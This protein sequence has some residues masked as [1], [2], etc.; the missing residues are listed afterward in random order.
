VYLIS[1]NPHQFKQWFIDKDFFG[2]A[3]IKKV[4]PVLIPELNYKEMDVLDGLKARRLWMKTVLEDKN[5][6][7][8]E[9]IIKNLIDYCTLDTFAMVRILEELKKI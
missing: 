8:R 7:N 3:S 5:N 6:E 4:L 1:T 9:E 2:S